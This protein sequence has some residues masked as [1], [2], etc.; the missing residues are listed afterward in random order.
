MMGPQKLWRSPWRSTQFLW[1]HHGKR[2]VRRLLVLPAFGLLGL[3]FGCGGGAARQDAILDSEW[4]PG[5][6]DAVSFPLQQ[7]IVLTVGVFAAPSVES[8][9]SL[10]W[11]EDKT[12]IHMEF[13]QLPTG[14]TGQIE[15]GLMLRERRAPDLIPEGMFSRDDTT[16]T[17][18]FINL[19]EFPGLT[20]KPLGLTME[21]RTFATTCAG[22]PP[23]L[24]GKPSA[25]KGMKVHL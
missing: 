16:L 10:A 24:P 22:E 3:L 17:G 25:Y 5:M 8:N 19:L 23:A 4:H 12:N 2:T 15:M 11:L 1:V 21:T 18:H 6:K 7:K 9:A 13:V 20:P 14:Q